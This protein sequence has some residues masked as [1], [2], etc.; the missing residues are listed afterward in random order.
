MLFK[1]IIAVLL[2]SQEIRGLLQ[3]M[4]C[5]GMLGQM[6]SIVNNCDVKP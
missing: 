3:K 6:V 5:F 1:E 4:Q 2:E